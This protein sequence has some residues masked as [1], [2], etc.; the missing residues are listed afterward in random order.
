MGPYLVS[1]AMSDTIVFLADREKKKSRK[2]LL[3]IISILILSIL[4]GTR[5]YTIGTDVNIYVISDFYLAKSYP[6]FIDLWSHNINGV[7]PLYLYTQHLA[8]KFFGTPHSILFVIALII[9][10]FF[11][12]GIQ[13]MTNNGEKWLP[14]LFYCFIFYNY[15]LNIMRQAVAMSIIFYLFSDPDKVPSL[16]KTIVFSLFASGFHR[17]GLIGLLIYGVLIIMQNKTLKKY[18]IGII[19]LCISLY[20]IL[21]IDNVSKYIIDSSTIYN[22]KYAH[23]AVSNS[24]AQVYSNIRDCIFKLPMVITYILLY[25]KMKKNFFETVPNTYSLL[26]G[27]A[28]LDIFTSLYTKLTIERIAY[29]F[30]IS[31]IQYFYYGTLLFSKR[32]IDRLIYIVFV[33][34]FVILH[35]Y[36]TFSVLG[37][38]QTVPYIFGGF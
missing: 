33:L 11:Y 25:K 4:A 18:K 12:L 28:I 23:Y 27:F 6:K 38:T 16:K 30:V 32:K 15:S 3:G 21:S 10:S 20:L 24:N 37:Y 17:F 8:A 34:I 35:W 9:N 13:K 14:W 29:L 36:I 1:F 22:Y 26:V 31:E 7:E 5:D 2:K 19:L